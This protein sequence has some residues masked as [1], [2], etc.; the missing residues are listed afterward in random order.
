MEKFLSHIVKHFNQI[1]DDDKLSQGE[2]DTK[3]VILGR[4]FRAEE[5]FKHTDTNMY[6]IGINSRGFITNHA[7]YPNLLGYKIDF[8][9][10]GSDIAEVLK[11]LN[12]ATTTETAD[13]E[14][15]Q[16]GSQDGSRVACAQKVDSTSGIVMVVAGLHH[17][18]GDS[19]I[20]LPDCSGFKLETTAKDVYEDQTM[21][22]LEDYVKGVIKA[23]QEMMSRIVKDVID[24]RGGP[25]A[26]APCKAAPR[27]NKQNSC[28]A[29]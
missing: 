10:A 4:A 3:T 21:A 29:L 11:K 8:D 23:G 27:L 14:T 20:N 16:D 2:R 24:E 25:A 19:A 26:L 15:Y 12:A 13:C 5:V 22:N 17:V 18:K 1:Q 28:T 6:T 9:A 7:I